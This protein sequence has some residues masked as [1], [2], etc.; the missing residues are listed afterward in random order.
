[1]KTIKH[2]AGK[3]FGH[4]F[5]AA[6]VALTIYHFL[7]WNESIGVNILIFNT[8]IISL[9]YIRQASLFRN[10]KVILSAIATVLTS[11]QVVILDTEMSVFGY[12]CAMAVFTGYV[13]RPEI[14]TVAGAAITGMLNIPSGF[15]HKC[16]VVKELFIKLTGM[17]RIWYI[18]KLMIIP[19][20]ILFVF[21]LIYS[22]A[23]PVFDSLSYTIFSKIKILC[24]Y[25]DK[26]L[27]IRWINFIIG[28]LIL[29]GGLLA[30]GKI[31]FLKNIEQQQKDTLFRR[32]NT[33]YISFDINTIGLKNEMKVGVLVMLLVNILLL[34][35]N[36]IDINWIWFN[37]SLSGNQTYAQLV[38]EGTYLLIFSILLSM[39]II[40]YFF[41]KNQNF[42]AN[43]KWLKRMAYG[44]VM[45]NMILVISV[46]I[47]NLRYINE[48][49]ITYRRIGVI[50]FLLFTIIGLILLYMRIRNRKTIF[51]S[52]KSGTL[53][54]FLIFLAFNF[55]NWDVVIV[56]YNLNKGG[57][58]VDTRYLLSFSDKTLP[59]LCQHF[60]VLKKT[61][62]TMAMTKLASRVIDS[63]NKKLHRNETFMSWN[64][65][66]FMIR[67]QLSKVTTVR[68][69]EKEGLPDSFR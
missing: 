39:G 47:R 43:N 22:I 19:A 9:H 53:A 26:Y 50:L 37:F 31:M 62:D 44:W 56:S 14:R 2:I 54:I 36:C 49:G 18:A 35:E 52:I 15:I 3:F 42:Y 8:I 4:P 1:M 57:T 25:L 29:T 38:H 66:N 40:F 34:I 21:T 11:V 60:G 30:D 67:R 12:V 33:S 63:K 65:A 69:P 58:A 17:R 6:L 46:V 32:K 24:D 64:Y 20:I 41:R 59:T 7:F 61:G 10:K 5:I 28:G 27:N 45:Q 48:Y 13:Y 51:Y 55:A 68:P 16:I 23:N